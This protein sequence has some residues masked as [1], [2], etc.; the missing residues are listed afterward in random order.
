VEVTLLVGAGASVA[1]GLPPTTKIT[2][3]VLSDPGLRVHSDRSIYRIP[4]GDLGLPGGPLTGDVF[5][6]ERRLP[7]DHYQAYLRTIRDEVARLL[8]YRTRRLP[9]YEDVYYVAKQIGY[10]RTGEALDPMAQSLWLRI[11]WRLPRETWFAIDDDPGTWDKNLLDYMRGA[12]AAILKG[13]K[14][15]ALNRLHMFEELE[16]DAGVSRV[17]VFTLNHDTV[18]EAYL[19]DRGAAYCDGLG[20]PDGELRWLD[21]DSYASSAAKLLIYK[22]HG[23]VDW[24]RYSGHVRSG[25][26]VRAPC[27]AGPVPTDGQGNL[28]PYYDPIP[29][30]VVGT[31]NKAE[32]YQWDPGLRL[33]CVF[34]EQLERTDRVVV[35]GH[36]FGDRVIRGHLANWLRGDTDRRL[37]VID[38]NA[39]SL[40]DENQWTV[41]PDRWELVGAP[42]A[43]VSWAEVK[44]RLHPNCP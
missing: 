2:S 39:Q 33:F 22:L 6:R 24:H 7:I 15:S 40:A 36:S 8:R 34:A 18:L 25:Y 12:V 11:A 28:I 19:R 30:I 37:V 38:R 35:V 41:F 10:H 17:H 42:I 13:C 4:Q 14:P 43:D 29:R 16:R 1:V 21:I 3:A 23:S 20:P 27:A 44:D 9:S 5:Y 26:A 32:E 31:L